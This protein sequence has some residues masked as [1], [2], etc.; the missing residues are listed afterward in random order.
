VIT[1]TPNRDAAQIVVSIKDARRPVDKIRA[2]PPQSVTISEPKP[3]W[4]SGFEE[5][6]QAPDFYIRTVTFSTL[7]EPATITIRKPIKSHFGENR[8]STIDL[9]LDRQVFASADK[10]RV[11]ATPVSKVG[12]PLSDANPRF[13]EL[14]QQLKTLLVQRVTNGSGAPTRPDPDEPY[15][16]LD[17]EESDMVTELHC[18]NVQCTELTVTT[19]EKTRVQ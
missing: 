10:C 1:V 4:V 2:T 12:W 15:P 5:P 18:K 6:T 14:M 13:P 11:E 8:I 9:D 3:G 19:A 16:P 7:D 17:V